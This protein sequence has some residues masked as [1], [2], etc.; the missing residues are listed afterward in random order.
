M[1]DSENHNLFTITVLSDA[2][3]EYK[4]KIN[5]KYADYTYTIRFWHGSGKLQIVLDSTNYIKG[6]WEFPLDMNQSAMADK[7]EADI[8]TMVIKKY[9]NSDFYD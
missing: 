5:M 2:L 7:I 6:K 4:F 1:V 8:N 3:L 9:N